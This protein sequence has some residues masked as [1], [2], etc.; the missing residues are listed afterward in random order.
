MTQIMKLDIYFRQVILGTSFGNTRVEDH[1]K[2]AELVKRLKDAPRR[3]IVPSKL[4]EV[5]SWKLI[6]H[7]YA[8]LGSLEASRSTTGFFSKGLKGDIDIIG[9]SLE[10]D[11]IGDIG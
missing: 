8:S 2:A 3:F 10:G 11:K 7:K 6:L 5:N 9:K 1:I 4:G